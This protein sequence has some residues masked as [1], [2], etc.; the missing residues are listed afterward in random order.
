MK[1][2][3]LLV[4][5]LACAHQPQLVPAP[6]APRAPDGSV[7][8]SAAGVEVRVDARRW[9]GS[10]SDLPNIVT[11]LWVSVTNESSSSVRIRYRDLKLVG[12]SGLETAA[13]PP[14]KLQRPGTE[15]I[16]VAPGFA[17]RGFFLYPPYRP[18][19]PGFPVWG[20]PW[21]YDPWFYDHA[22]GTWQPSLPT[23]DM[24]RQALPEGAL[25]PRGSA[26][27]FLYFHHL[28]DKGPVTF[29][30]ELIDAESRALL[31]TVQIP[32]LLQ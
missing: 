9:S 32:L 23:P 11:P 28:R 12:P 25:Q 24:L 20:G 16:V 26:A 14:L 1:R 29:E 5:V 6:G 18:F 19:Y 31:G 30:A 17:S 13:I 15:S 21:D 10:P 22:Y 2:F 7:A 27:G 8:A 4:F 3:V